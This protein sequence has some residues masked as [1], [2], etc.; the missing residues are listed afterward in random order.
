MDQYVDKFTSEGRWINFALFE[1][2][3]T[4]PA[5]IAVWLCYLFVFIF[6]YQVCRGMKQ[7]PWLALCFG[8]V[9]VNV[10]YFTMLFKWP[11]TLIPGTLMLAVF[12]CL[13]ERYNRTTLLLISG[14]TL[15]ATYPAFYFLMPLLFIR[16]L[17]SESYPRLVNFLVIWMIGY[18]VGYAVAQGTVYAYTA[19]WTDHSQFIQ[20]ASWRK[21]TPTTDFASLVNNIAKSS[22]NF[23]R[24]ALYLANLSPLF[25]LPIAVVALWKLKQQSKY[26]VVVLLII[27]SL[28]ASVVV[29]GV[30]V[31][32]RSGITLPIGLMMIALLVQHP[33][34]RFILLLTLFIPFAY[35]THHYNHGYNEKRIMIANILEANDPHGYLKQSDRFKQVIISLDE[36]KSSRYFYDRTGSQA[37]QNIIYLRTHYIQPYLYKFGWRKTEIKVEAI[38]RTKIQGKARVTVDGKTVHLDLD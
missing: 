15:F 9:M 31:P 3:R 28:Y 37:F 13:R 20:F 27:L 36:A 21:S 34:E 1:F 10:P 8:L 33:W 29:L 25:Y 24:N 7:A 14:V 35:L 18:G 26:I 17:S 12:A 19:L 38:E 16:Q 32:L 4:I 23:K 6:G 11:M 5:V 2:L 30:K 22:G